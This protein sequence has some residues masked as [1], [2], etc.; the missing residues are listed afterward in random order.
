MGYTY[1]Q[2][3]GQCCGVYMLSITWSVL[4]GIHISIPWSV[5]WAMH[6]VNSMDSAIRYTR[7][8]LFGSMLCDMH[9]ANY[10][11]IAM[12]YTWSQFFLPVI[13]GIH[14]YIDFG[15]CSGIYIMIYILGS[16][17]GLCM[18]IMMLFITMGY[19]YNHSGQSYVWDLLEKSTIDQHWRISDTEYTYLL[20]L[21]STML[22]IT[23]SAQG[24]WKCCQL[25]DQSY[26]VYMFHFHS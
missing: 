8:Q 5:Q 1:W 6:V 12:W 10:L 22:L 20:I 3:L 7:C 11:V 25:Y 26:G 17:I 16:T 18:F 19:R 14:V 23:W 13:W 4:W 24:I 9:V 2:L 15:Q 21:I